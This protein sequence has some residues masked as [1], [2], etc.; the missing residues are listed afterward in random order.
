MI[1]AEMWYELLK[2]YNHWIFEFISSMTE[3]II[4]GLIF[5]PLFRRWLK[6]HDA[7]KHAHQHCED[8]H[9]EESDR[10]HFTF[11]NKMLEWDPVESMWYCPNTW[12][13]G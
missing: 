8:V 6:H 7:K 11:C 3:N 10:C 2:D 4:L 13:H 1:I 9:D 5:L 12:D